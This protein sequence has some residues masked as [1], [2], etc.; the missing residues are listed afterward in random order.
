MMLDRKGSVLYVGKAKNLRRRIRSYFHKSKKPAKVE[1][2]LKRV[3]KVEFIQ[4]ESERAALVLESRLI[5][6]LWPPYNSLGKETPRYPFVMLDRSDFPAPTVVSS[7]SKPGSY[8]G[9]FASAGAL[10]ALL[11]LARDEFGLRRCKTIESKPCFYYEIKRCVGPCTGLVDREDYS[12]RLSP[13]IEAL[14]GNPSRLKAA[15]EKRMAIASENLDFER[16][17]RCRNAVHALST[18]PFARI[19]SPSS[20][21]PPFPPPS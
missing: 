1:R 3:Y 15:I 12:E 6:E 17:A 9:P 14:E 21:S 18:P 4:T 19:S 2:L 5:R 16:A 11:E 7:I 20:F 10:E 13:L 8:Y